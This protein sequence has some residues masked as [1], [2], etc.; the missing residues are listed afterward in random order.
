MIHK[1]LA[2]ERSRSLSQLSNNGRTSLR[3]RIPRH[4]AIVIDKSSL[5]FVL[6][7]LKKWLLNGLWYCFDILFQLCFLADFPEFGRNLLP[8]VRKRPYWMIIS[9]CSSTPFV[10]SCSL[11]RAN[12]RVR[13]GFPSSV[14]SSAYSSW[15]SY[16]NIY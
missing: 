10:P 11:V 14:L 9:D 7:L 16:G 3:R 13:N 8:D 12:F 15:V 2:V 1:P 4:C 5:H 6:V